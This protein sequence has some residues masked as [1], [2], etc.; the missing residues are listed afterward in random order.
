MCQ[1]V[2]KKE[3]YVEPM[4]GPSVLGE[5]SIRTLSRD[6]ELRSVVRGTLGRNRDGTRITK[7]TQSK[8]RRWFGDF[9]MTQETVAECHKQETNKVD[10]GRTM[11]TEKMSPL[12]PKWV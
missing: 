2:R 8:K 1:V 11:G 6:Q 4:E 12:E 5:S 10:S 9:R 7:Q 3:D